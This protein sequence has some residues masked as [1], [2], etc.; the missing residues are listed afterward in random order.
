MSRLEEKL[1]ETEKGC[2]L[3]LTEPLC[4]IDTRKRLFSDIVRDYGSINGRRAEI[5]IKRH[6]RD[7]LRYG[8]I[9]PDAVVLDSPFPME[10]LN[11]MKGVR[12]DR[13]VSVYTVLDSFEDT[14]EKVYLG[15]DFM[16]RYEDPSLHRKNE[17]I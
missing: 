7:I 11:L 5:I 17:R 1:K 15:N 10:I 16:D 4:D 13:I 9:F 8:E 3:I 6:P 2:V 14:V 12:F